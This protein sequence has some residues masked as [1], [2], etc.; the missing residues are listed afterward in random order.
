[1]EILVVGVDLETKDEVAVHMHEKSEDISM[2]VLQ[3]LSG[4]SHHS[5]AWPCQILRI[6]IS[7]HLQHTY[8][9]WQKDVAL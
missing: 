9:K 7:L 3:A 5:S 8:F 1:M 6:F 4:E 2:N